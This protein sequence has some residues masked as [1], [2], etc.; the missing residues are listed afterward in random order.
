MGGLVRA[1]LVVCLLATLY[2]QLVAAQNATVTQPV[3]IQP[4]PVPRVVEERFVKGLGKV[5]VEVP[6]VIEPGKKYTVSFRVEV[7]REEVKKLLWLLE[8]VCRLLCTLPQT[9][10]YMPSAL[11][12][13]CGYEKLY[14][15]GYGGLRGYAVPGDK[16]G[17]AA[18]VAL[19]LQ[20][21]YY[22]VPISS[23]TYL[24]GSE[25]SEIFSVHYV[26]EGPPPLSLSD[27]ESRGPPYSLRL[28]PLGPAA[29]ELTGAQ[30]TFELRYEVELVPNAAYATLFDLSVG[31]AVYNST[32]YTDDTLPQ[33]SAVL[34]ALQELGKA[35]QLEGELA[36]TRSE[37]E[38]CR[39]DAEELGAALQRCEQELQRCKQELSTAGSTQPATQPSQP[40]PSFT[41]INV[42]PIAALALI[43]L[44]VTL[45][46][47]PALKRKS[48]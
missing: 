18:F 21:V 19:G 7:N 44:A 28:T 36:S 40:Q 13:A 12:R 29:Q 38:Q 47:Y 20:Q 25:V 17:I 3:P 15:T 9:A 5:R 24:V 23:Q 41:P 30:G 1:A 31:R 37:L 6:S 43:A 45:L 4:T 48:A 11:C 16:I 14:V 32:Q 39:R 46:L 42:A 2:L 10:S 35:S 33:A 27:L 8:Q 34:A 26:I 22:S